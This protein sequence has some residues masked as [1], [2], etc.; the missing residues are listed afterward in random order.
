VLP[1]TL[2]GLDMATG[3]R[4][5]AGQPALYR[6][7]LELFAQSRAGMPATIG[8]Q[9]RGGDLA[10][11]ASALHMLKSEAGTIGATAL[12]EATRTLEAA[13]RSGERAAIDAALPAFE[14]EL[15]QVLD[16]LAAAFGTP[17]ASAQASRLS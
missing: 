16:G 7:V 2:P 9:C 6:R 12:R 3:L 14:A 4:F 11:A 10:A 17:A 13:V 5:A 15:R 1:P 8:E